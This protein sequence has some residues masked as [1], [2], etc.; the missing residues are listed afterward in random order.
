M[1]KEMLAKCEGHLVRI[2]PIARRF[3]GSRELEQIDDDWRI[4]RV[5]A[6]RKIVEIHNLR[7]AH[8]LT[9]GLDHIHSYTSDPMRDTDGQKHGFLHL[10]VEI[11]L[12]DQGPTIEPLPPAERGGSRTA[13]GRVPRLESATQIVDKWVDQSYPEKAGITRKLTAEDFDLSWTRANE[14]S[15]KVDLQS[16]EPVVVEL[17]DGTN[18]RLKIRDHPAVGGYLILLRRKRV[19]QRKV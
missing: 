18:A 15:E 10:I 11:R 12:T 16:W 5:D 7:C 17:A 9:I 13:R 14:E 2:R 6:A 4:T 3:Q 1:N 19:D 8:C